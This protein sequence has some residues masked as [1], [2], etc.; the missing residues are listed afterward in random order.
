MAKVSIYKMVLTAEALRRRA[1][2][3]SHRQEELVGQH[4]RS[5]A[6]DKPGHIHLLILASVSAMADRRSAAAR[7]VFPI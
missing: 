6:G 4:K 1:G 2:K 5:V 7:K 3:G